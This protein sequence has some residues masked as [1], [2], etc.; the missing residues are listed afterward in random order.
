MRIAIL[1]DDP[2][3]QELLVRTLVQH[4]VGMDTVRCQV[5][6]NGKQLQRLLRRESFDLLILDWSV[7]SLDGMELLH[8]LRTWKSNRVP[9]LMLSSRGAEQDV[10]DALAAGAD[11]YVIKPFR[12]LELRARVRRL[13][14]NGSGG[15]VRTHQSIG[16]W[17]LDAGARSISYLAE[18]DAQTETHVLTSRE[19][20]LVQLLFNRPGQTVSRAHLLEAAGYE[21]EEEPSRTL[22]SH[23]YRLRRKL[24]LDAGRGVSLRAVYGQGYCLDVAKDAS[25]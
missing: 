2:V 7:P 21:T 4:L 23:I 6:D 16:R 22:D 14:Q 11:D 25:A 13:V 24:Q 8:W 17:T 19:F 12:P 1:E 20:Q 3:Q 9:V 10:A 18:P 15:P 5:F